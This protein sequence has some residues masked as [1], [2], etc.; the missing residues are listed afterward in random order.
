MKKL[1][2]ALLLLC[3]VAIS[4]LADQ[5]AWCITLPQKDNPGWCS[6]GLDGRGKC[7]VIRIDDAPRCSADQP[8]E[9][10]EGDDLDS[11]LEP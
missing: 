3:A 9:E 10:E 5:S 4:A 8:E 6:E 2:I 1:I 11:I 7:V